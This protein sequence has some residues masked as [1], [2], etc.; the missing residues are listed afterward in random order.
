VVIR[1][2]N[3][4]ENHVSFGN[5]FCFYTYHFRICGK[6]G[7]RDENQMVYCG[8]GNINDSVFLRLYFQNPIFY[9]DIPIFSRF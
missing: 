7:V 4:E 8:N 9:R 6:N 3:G 1:D 5:A 2:E